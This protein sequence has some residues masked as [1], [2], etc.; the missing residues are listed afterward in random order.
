MLFSPFSPFSR[1]LTAELRG[2]RNQAGF[3]LLELIVVI[4]VIGILAAIALPNLVQTPRRA[5]EAVLKTNLHTL[6]EVIDQ[7]YGDKGLYPPDL[8]ALV[9]EGYIREVPMD[10]MYGEA[11]WGVIFEDEAGLGDLD[12]PGSVAWDV[13]L[14]VEGGGI[15]DVYS[16]SEDLSLD[17]EPYAEW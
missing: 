5:R 9:D 14:E 3:T 12:D 1:R 6:R 11:E 8:E 13:D 2:K 15:I 7:H 10:P 16:L 4:A 17:G